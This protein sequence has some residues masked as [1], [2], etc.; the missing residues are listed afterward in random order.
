M[1]YC[2]HELARVIQEQLPRIIFLIVHFGVYLM[3][4]C[5]NYFLSMF[6]F[7]TRNNDIFLRPKIYYIF[8]DLPQSSLQQVT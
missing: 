5:H 8:L 2:S 7:H 3:E 4:F 6:T 1:I